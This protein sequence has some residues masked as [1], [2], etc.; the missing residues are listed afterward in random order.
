MPRE[1]RRN[2]CDALACTRMHAHFPCPSHTR[3]NEKRSGKESGVCSGKRMGH[4]RV[5]AR[6]PRA[7][8]RWLITRRRDGRGPGDAMKE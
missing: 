1:S 7:W 8:G 2:P 3:V 5:H 6:A 4:E